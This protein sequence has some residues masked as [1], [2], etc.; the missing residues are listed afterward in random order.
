MLKTNGLLG[1]LWI[2]RKDFLRRIHRRMI[3]VH[4]QHHFYLQFWS[5][6]TFVQRLLT[7][8]P[9]DV[10]WPQKQFVART[11]ALLLRHLFLTVCQ[12]SY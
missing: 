9:P 7:C 3:E 5:C 1:F 10:L 6:V 8:Q 4:H 12:C 11:V 2:T